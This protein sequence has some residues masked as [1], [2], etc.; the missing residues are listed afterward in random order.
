MLRTLALLSLLAALTACGGS[1]EAPFP[2]GVAPWTANTAPAPAPLPDEPYPEVLSTVS[3]ED[4]DGHWIHA[5]G[6]LHADAAT[7]WTGLQDPAVMADRRGVDSWAPRWDVEPGFDVSVA[8]DNVVNDVITLSWT[9]TWRQSLVDGDADKPVL[10]GA[11]YQKTDGSSLIA[12]LRGSVVL[13]QTDQLN[14]T[15]I[16]LMEQLS[17]PLVTDDD[18]RC[19]QQDLFDELALAARGEPLPEYVGSCR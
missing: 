1:T 10:I 17:A 15:E 5:R 12:L 19:Y 3:G 18:L 13:R 7:V 16:E 8:I 11:R 2:E 14:R 9:N 6:Y 4:A